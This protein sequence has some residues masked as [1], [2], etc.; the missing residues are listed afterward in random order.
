MRHCVRKDYLNSKI[1]TKH[2]FAFQQM[3]LE[4]HYTIAYSVVFN[5][6]SLKTVLKTGAQ[7]ALTDKNGDTERNIVKMD[8]AKAVSSFKSMKPSL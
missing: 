3:C 8:I 4:N 6:Y 1:Y 7:I 5:K 2:M